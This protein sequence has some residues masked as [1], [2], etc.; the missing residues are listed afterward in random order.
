MNQ[1]ASDIK[2][3][4]LK[5]T[6]DRLSKVIDRQ[7]SMLESLER[8]IHEKESREAELLQTIRNLE[9]QLAYM[10]QKQ[11]GA[12]SERRPVLPGQMNLFDEPGDEI[13]EV[14][15]IEAEFIPVR[16]AKKTR[17]PKASYD[18]IFAGIPA[19]KEYVDTLS[20]EAKVC[21][22]CGSNLVAIG[23]EL[24]RTELIYHPAKLERIDYMSTSYTCPECKK[25]AAEPGDCCI[26]KDEGSPA[27]I[28]GSY[29]SESIAAWTM[30]QKFCNSMPFYRQSKDMEQ[31]GVKVNRTTMANWAIYCT[32][33]YFR[34]MY[35][36]FRRELL[37]R[38]FFMADE[39]PVQVLHE[40]GR[41]AQTKSYV[42]LVR[43][44]EDDLPDII[45]YRYTPTRAGNNI[46]EFLAEAAQD[47]YLMVDGYQGYNKVKGV[48]LC[49]CWAHVRRYLLEAIPKGRENDYA[50]PAVQGVLYIDKLFMY[51][52]SY[53]EKGLSHK[54]IYRRRL[55]DEKPVL[56]AF[57]LW[58]DKLRP[59]RGS[60]LDRAQKYIANRRANLQ[61]YLEDGRCSFSNNL[62]E[63]SIRPFTVGRKNW[64]FCDTPDGAEA[65]MV[66]YTMVEMAKAYNLKIYD[67]LKFLLEA[68]PS[69]DMTDEELDA[70]APWS[71]RA[72]EA[73]QREKAE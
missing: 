26:I 49:N 69:D 27:L 58:F 9:A 51:E 41:R 5:D 20:E 40:D 64:L 70:L 43:S 56:E 25:T 13:R 31:Y 62:S 22:D 47:A 38:Q 6:I 7:N 39:T 16:K 34:P 66:I 57:W 18:E 73:C 30:Y 23:H 65:N 37:K 29:A 14:Q 61:T 45:L 21:P 60:R 36:Y 12:S 11:F 42:W 35:E 24:I 52:R 54:Q 2:F 46:A 4:E 59:V 17:K 19:R 10:K 44:G 71:S 1:G 33:H 53:R 15:Q 67:Y 63:N 68:R 48:K 55:K 72:Q 28:P 8:T 50:E 3:I 32:Q